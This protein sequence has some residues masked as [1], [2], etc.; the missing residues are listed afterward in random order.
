MIILYIY[1]IGLLPYQIE[2]KE[3]KNMLLHF[4][5][6]KDKDKDRPR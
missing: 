6:I 3:I 2:I 5:L 1:L 4:L